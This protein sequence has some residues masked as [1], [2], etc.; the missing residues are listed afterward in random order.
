MDAEDEE[1]TFVPR[2]VRFPVELRPPEGFEPERLETWPRVA[3]RLEY[4]NGR[5]LYM[6]P[7]GDRQQLT[8]ADVVITLGPW[9]R[10]NPSFVLGTNEAG[11]LLAGD[12]RGADAAIWHWPEDTQLTGGF[13]RM[14]PLLAVEV[15]GRD[16]AEEDL[17]EK[18]IWYLG[19]GVPTVWVVLPKTREVVVVTEVGRVRHRVG[20]R[21]PEPAGLVGLS[22]SVGDFFLQLRG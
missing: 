20:E 22:P 1:L 12:V 10:A 19:H 8:V 14:P 16:E 3:G 17:L 6:P 11:F 9:V 5:L 4:V 15:A 21:V 2:A 18:S 7:C 13:R